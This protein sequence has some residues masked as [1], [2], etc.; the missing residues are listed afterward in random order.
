MASR[1]LISRRLITIVPSL[2]VFVKQFTDLSSNI[3]RRIPSSEFHSNDILVNDAFISS[4]D[5][6]KSNFVTLQNNSLKNVLNKNITDPLSLPFGIPLVPSSIDCLECVAHECSQLFIREFQDLFPGHS[7]DKGL[8]IVT[9]SQ[10]TINDMSA[11]TSKV[12]EE[13]DLLLE[14]FVNGAK[15]ICLSIRSCGYWADFVDPSSGLPY[16]GEHTNAP[17]FETDDRYNQLG[18]EI[19]DLGCCKVIRH[20]SWGTHAYVGTLFTDAG[21]DLPILKNILI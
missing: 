17:F 18:F 1:I 8:T 19:E 9:L 14:K 4:T 21:L 15:Q 3:V 16:F 13:R 5:L 6:N 10:K 11:W 2:N 7:L 20:K 12:E